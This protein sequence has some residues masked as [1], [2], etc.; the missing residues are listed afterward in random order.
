[1]ASQEEILQDLSSMEKDSYKNIIDA[2]KKLSKDKQVKFV[3][4]G[5]FL[6]EKLE[7]TTNLL[8]YIQDEYKS[9]DL[10]TDYLVFRSILTDISGQDDSLDSL[11]GTISQTVYGDVRVQRQLQRDVSELTTR[12]SLLQVDVLGRLDTFDTDLDDLKNKLES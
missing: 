1:M 2:S 5:A 4:L 11:N 12:N 6:N 9:S 8:K 7:K 3:M 10:Q